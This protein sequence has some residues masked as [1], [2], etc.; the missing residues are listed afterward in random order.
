MS[1]YF[2]HRSEWRNFSVSFV[3]VG[4]S[5]TGLSHHALLTFSTTPFFFLPTFNSLGRNNFSSCTKP[6]TLLFIHRFRYYSKRITNPLW[7]TSGQ[8]FMFLL[9]IHVN[10]GNDIRSRNFN[11]ILHKSRTRGVKMF[12]TLPFFSLLVFNDL[13]QKWTLK[14]L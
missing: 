14:N 3:Y 9:F 5:L 12:A 13:I 1:R 2:F 4:I 10:S 11:S 6:V 7:S 8:N